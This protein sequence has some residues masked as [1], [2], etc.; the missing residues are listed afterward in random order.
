VIAAPAA[1]Y[2]FGPGDLRE[3]SA[4]IQLWRAENDSQAPDAWNGAIVRDNL[5][6]HPDSHVVQ[7]VDHFVFLAPC[8]E[9]LAAAAAPICRDSNGFDRAAFHRTFNQSVVDFFS[10]HLR[11]R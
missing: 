4:P 1:S 3:V 9:S 10:T 7:G 11:D 5:T 6:V 8:S 2:L